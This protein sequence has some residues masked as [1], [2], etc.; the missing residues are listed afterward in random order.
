MICDGGAEDALQDP[1]Q[2]VLFTVFV[3]CYYRWDESDVKVTDYTLA[4]AQ[5]LLWCSNWSL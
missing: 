4:V 2:L 5:L 1:G 3:Q